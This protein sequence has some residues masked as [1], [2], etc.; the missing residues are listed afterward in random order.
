MAVKGFY[1]AVMAAWAVVAGF[2]LYAWLVRDIKK[3][4]TRIV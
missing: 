3:A 2:S 4:A 1:V